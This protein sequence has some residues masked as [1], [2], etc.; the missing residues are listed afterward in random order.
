MSSDRKKENASLKAC[1][2]YCSYS[3]LVEGKDKILHSSGTLLSSIESRVSKQVFNM[4]NREN[5]NTKADLIRKCAF[6]PVEVRLALSSSPGV[7]EDKPVFRQDY[8]VVLFVDISGFT[9][10][11]RKY[12]REFSEKLATDNLSRDIVDALEILTEICLEYG[13]DVAKFAGD[14]L[15]CIWKVNQDDESDLR[16]ALRLARKAAY[17]MMEKVKFRFILVR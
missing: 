16:S 7:P 11:G 10:L 15:L 6:L 2:S 1:G 8:G 13:G 4:I 3:D 14:A 12:R 9:A 5:N 17:D